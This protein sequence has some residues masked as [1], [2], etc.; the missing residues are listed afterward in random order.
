MFAENVKYVRERIEE[1]RE[2][3]GRSDDV[4]L[5]AVS[6]TFPES[7]IEEAYTAGHREFGENRIQ[8]AVAKAD[9]FRD[10]E[11]L[12]LHFIG[13]LQTNKVRYLKDNFAL[14]H[15]LDRLS[16]LKEMQKHFAKEGRVQDVLVQVNVAEDPDKSGVSIDGLIE[17]LDKTAAAE[18]LNLCGLTMMPPLVD[19]HEKNR[20]HF[21]KTRE[22]YD[23]YK[24]SYGLSILSMGMSGDYEIAVEEGSTLVRVG[25]AL[26]G[27]RDY[28]KVK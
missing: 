19:D 4:T 10:Y 7:M 25:T 26:F 20:V 17:L 13:H 15:S 6:K 2:R 11:G 12:R 1:A 3:G 5:L 9:Y 28:S 8:E 24:D 21:A 23:K 16:L 14:I 18:N 27:K 22:L